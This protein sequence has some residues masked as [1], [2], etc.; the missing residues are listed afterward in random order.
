MI[1]L[2]IWGADK[3]VSI[4]DPESLASAWLLS[5][6]LTPQQIPYD[7]V[8][9]CNTNLSDS[10][11]LPLLLVRG[12][13]TTR[14]YEGFSEISHFISEKF[15]AD[16]TKYVPDVKLSTTD[17]LANFS[18]IS[19]LNNT[20]KYVNQYNLYVNTENY[21]NYTRKLFS[22]YLPFPMMYNQPLKFF[23]SA[24]EQVK[25]IGL[26]VNKTSLFSFSVG[27]ETPETETFNDENEGEQD[28]VA[29]SS[30][31]EKVMLAKLK[32]KAILR[33]S[34]N[35]LRCL[36]ILGEQISHVERLF[37][38]LNPNSP[39][40][41]AHLFRAKKISS[42]EL[43]LYAYFH[44]LTFAGLPDNFIANYLKQKSPAF[45]KFAYTITEA[46]N[47]SLVPETFRSALGLEVPSLKNEV[48][49]LMS[50]VRY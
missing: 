46:L 34:R 10:G 41:F 8:T 48:L 40:D 37:K 50:L 39:V 28:E 18:L 14:K 11:R 13:G 15:P 16:S 9:S 5:I 4:I 22:S 19:F 44:S 29:I 36:N 6:H 45:W 26:G 49:Y 30:L 2:H 27:D 23:K 24:S 12:N 47:T 3:Q 25:I 43:L 20:I 35:S 1:E 32:D 31:H 42:S 7:I 33:E 17:Q 38:Q 21:E